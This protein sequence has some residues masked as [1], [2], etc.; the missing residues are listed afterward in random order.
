MLA[1]PNTGTAFSLAA[2]ICRSLLQPHESTANENTRVPPVSHAVS[3]SGSTPGGHMV[4][5]GVASPLQRRLTCCWPAL[6][7]INTVNCPS[8][9]PAPEHQTDNLLL[10][11]GPL[12]RAAANISNPASTAATRRCVQRAKRSPRPV[13][14]R[15]CKGSQDGWERDP[16]KTLLSCTCVPCRSEKPSHPS[17]HLTLRTLRQ[18]LQYYISLPYVPILPP[19]NPPSSAK[20]PPVPCAKWTNLLPDIFRR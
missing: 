3:L 4:D 11:T 18:Y 13:D 20:P 10:L 1:A 2:S 12:A 5:R 8:R 17:S 19:P 6:V 14:R 15:G 16:Q 7:S 9:A